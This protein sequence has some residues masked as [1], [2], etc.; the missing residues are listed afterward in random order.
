MPMIGRESE[1]AMLATSDDRQKSI[2]KKKDAG[3]D[4]GASRSE[5]AGKIKISSR[6]VGNGSPVEDIAQD[7]QHDLMMRRTRVGI[8]RRRLSAPRCWS[9]L[10]VTTSMTFG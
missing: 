7:M 2:S 6:S 4:E 5:L 1:L 9:G 8:P 3:E 10:C